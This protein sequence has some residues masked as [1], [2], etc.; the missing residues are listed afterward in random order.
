[1]RDFNIIGEIAEDSLVLADD[2]DDEI[3]CFLDEGSVVLELSESFVDEVLVV[4]VIL[5]HDDEKFE[6]SLENLNFIVQILT[7]LLHA[8]LVDLMNCLEERFADR[9]ALEFHPPVL[10]VRVV[11]VDVNLCEHDSLHFKD[12]SQRGLRESQLS[13]LVP[14]VIP[15]LADSSQIRFGDDRFDYFN[16]LI[17][18]V[19][20]LDYLLSVRTDFG[21][22]PLVLDVS[23]HDLVQTEK[24]N[25][26][27]RLI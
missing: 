26:F 15:F 18:D 11:Q 20:L 17:E 27:N 14:L 8:V 6:D 3:R 5:T 23:Q 19:L 9:P 24:F 10:R 16:E 22:V 7:I 25:V 4:E 21:E 2:R 1:M 12:E 13:C